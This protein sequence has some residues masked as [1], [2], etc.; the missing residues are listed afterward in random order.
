M[1][2]GYISTG[3]GYHFS[4]LLVFLMALRSRQ[5]TETPFSLVSFQT[6]RT[7]DKGIITPFVLGHVVFKYKI[8]A[9]LFSQL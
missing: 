6:P 4:V 8:F 2:M 7:N 9:D 3:M 5:E 1:A